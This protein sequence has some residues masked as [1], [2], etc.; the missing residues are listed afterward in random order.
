[1]SKENVNVNFVRPEI[2][3]MQNTYDLIKDCLDGQEAVKDAGEKYLPKPNPTDKSKEN[4][5]RYEAYVQR[6]VFYNVT[7]GTLSGLVGQIF[8]RDPEVKLPTNLKMIEEDADGSGVSLVQLCKKSARSVIG[9]GREGL[10]VDYPV[11]DKP[12][13]VS[14][15]KKGFIRP[16]IHTYEPWNVINWKT[17]TIG[18]K[19]QLSLVV[20]VEYVDTPLCSF[21]TQ[22][23]KQYRVLSLGVT[24]CNNTKGLNKTDAVYTVEVWHNVDENDPDNYTVKESYQPVDSNGA[25]LTSIPFTFIGATNNDFEVDNA[26]MADLAN[27][28]IA[29][30]RNSADYEESCYMVGQPTPWFSGLTDYWV[31]Q[32]FK[33]GQIQLGSRAAVPL[34]EN[35][36]A[37][38]LQAEQ[39]SMPI[40]AMKLKQDQMVAIGAKL[41]ERSNVE[42]TATE[43]TIE[44]SSE[45]SVLES[46][47]K[48][49]NESYNKA[50]KWAA[51]FTG[52]AESSVEFKLND[53]FKIASMTPEERRQQLEEWQ[54]GLISWTEA[55][56]NLRRSNVT[57]MS[58]D[59]A[60]SEI[61][62]EETAREERMRKIDALTN[63]KSG[64]SVGK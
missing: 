52:D 63:S 34:P 13:T 10:L 26:P 15:M 56:E 57:S 42:R 12:I 20:I 58:D 48:N 39:N 47:T 3:K 5:K 11:T 27:L 54:G 32:V 49:L 36:N 64:E 9:Y 18:A 44:R 14:D 62:K 8:M 24:S 50:L 59:D 2:A 16:V 1:M 43:V 30:Y 25:N 23:T 41:I 7:S 55:R 6:A 61:A 37:G 21:A 53:D 28:N 17:R 29:H 35:A 31:K 46:T 4:T 40:E 38:L 33:D 51:M 60:K 45:M 19:Q 22:Q